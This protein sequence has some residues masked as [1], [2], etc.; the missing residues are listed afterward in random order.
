MRL[1][2][3]DPKIDL[4]QRAETAVRG[5]KPLLART[6]AFS[7][8]ATPGPHSKNRRGT[9]YSFWQFRDAEPG[10]ALRHIDWRQ[11]AKSDQLFVREKE[12]ESCNSIFFWPDNSLSMQFAG[13]SGS[14]SKAD[15]A[16]L[17]AIA[18]ALLLTRSDERVGILGGSAP[19][20]GRS[21]ISQLIDDAFM[22]SDKDYSSPP[23]LPMPA[24][25]HL[26][27]LSDFLGPWDEIESS[28]RRIAGLRV[29]ATFIQVLDPAECSFPYAGRIQFRSVGGTARHE[30]LK[31]EAMRDQY[32]ARLR[33][34]Q[35]QLN[36]LGTTYQWSNLVHQTHEAVP[37]VLL[38]LGNIL[39]PERV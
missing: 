12:L 31:A 8:S 7:N 9:G 17:I 6:A 18:A 16:R 10:E 38:W 21:R 5:L 26:V 33:S 14:R 3:P 20:S 22:Q 29:K 30:T 39:M 37:P 15:R 36:E 19:I 28:A 34:R 4:T 35:A 1:D 2:T 11:S 32:R 25:S 24:G 13:K 23:E 27:V